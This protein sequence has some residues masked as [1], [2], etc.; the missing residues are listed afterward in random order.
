MRQKR[1]QAAGNA[2]TSIFL[3]GDGQLHEIGEP[4]IIGNGHTVNTSIGYRAAQIFGRALS[5]IGGDPIKVV[6]HL[7]AGQTDGLGR[8]LRQRSIRILSTGQAAGQLKN[9]LVIRRGQPEDVHRDAHRERCGDGREIEYVGTTGDPPHCLMRAIGH[10][11]FEIG[12]P[13]RRKPRQSDVAIGAMV[14]IIHLNEAA[15]NI[16]LA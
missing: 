2:A 14:R 15:Q 1:V 10:P 4:L 9:E 3:A 7:D 16:R 6:A 13:G 8:T 5:P 11:T 12:E